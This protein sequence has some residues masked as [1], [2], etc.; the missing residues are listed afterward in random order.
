MIVE[1]GKIMNVTQKSSLPMP[2]FAMQEDKTRDDYFIGFIKN[3]L[4]KVK[5]WHWVKRNKNEDVTSPFKRASSIIN[6]LC[7]LFQRSIR[8]SKELSWKKHNCHLDIFKI[9]SSMLTIQQKYLNY[10]PG[11]KFPRGSRRVLYTWARGSHLVAGLNKSPALGV[12]NCTKWAQIH[13]VWHHPS[14]SFINSPAP[15]SSH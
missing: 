9:Y 7:N 15:H 11:E 4:L 14:R 8:G 3:I 6:Y 1:R 12:C 13:L 2:C 10:K 5:K